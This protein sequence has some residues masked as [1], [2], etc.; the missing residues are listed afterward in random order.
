MRTADTL[1][2]H[3]V[4]APFTKWDMSAHVVIPLLM[5]RLIE[6][7]LSLDCSSLILLVILFAL[8]PDFV[9][10]V[11]KRVMAGFMRSYL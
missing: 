8:F 11:G 5:S 2:R 3:T 4:R 1:A 10:L 9:A 6:H 7:L